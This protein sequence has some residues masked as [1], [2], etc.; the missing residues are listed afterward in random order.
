[1]TCRDPSRPMACLCWRGAHRVP[2]HLKTL[3]ARAIT[4]PRMAIDMNDCSD[5]VIFAHVIEP[6]LYRKVQRA[7]TDELGSLA[8]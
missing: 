6:S 3:S 5:I 8:W 7:L 4:R 1:M 2:A